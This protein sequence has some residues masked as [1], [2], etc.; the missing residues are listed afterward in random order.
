[1]PTA[2]LEAQ[3]LALIPEDYAEHYER[4]LGAPAIDAP[5][6][7]LLL[8]RH[9]CQVLQV[10]SLLP[11]IDGSMAERLVG[12]LL[13]LHA[14]HPRCSIVDAAIRYFLEHDDDDEITGVLGY[15][16]DRA[17]VRAVLDVLHADDLLEELLQV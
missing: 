7:P 5:E 4:L 13:A 15:D 9:L 6:V 17:V 2:P 1:M 10:A 11:H 16:D 12:I 8:S 14:R 3:V